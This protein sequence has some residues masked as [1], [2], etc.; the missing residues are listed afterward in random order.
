MS[1]V[2][3]KP[4]CL[5]LSG[6]SGGTQ[7]YCYSGSIANTRDLP[8]GCYSGGQASGAGC[9][10]G[11]TPSTAGCV[12]GTTPVNYG[13]IPGIQATP[14]CGGGTEPKGSCGTGTSIV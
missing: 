5:K 1:L 6:L 2:Y 3:V 8:N 7:G 9:G 11:G 4:S 10:F 13:C 12:T 14:A